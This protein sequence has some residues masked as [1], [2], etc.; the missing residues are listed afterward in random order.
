MRNYFINENNIFLNSA[1]TCLFKCVRANS[2]KNWPNLKWKTAFHAMAD[3][4]PWRLHH[5]FQRK[6]CRHYECNHI[7]LFAHS[8]QTFFPFPSSCTSTYTNTQ[9]IPK[10]LHK[11]KDVCQRVIFFP[12]TVR[13]TLHKHNVIHWQEPLWELAEIN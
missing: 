1:I 5:G 6:F 12:S 2:M 4:I 9:R 11:H 13:D 7:F 3:I 8:Y 10:Q